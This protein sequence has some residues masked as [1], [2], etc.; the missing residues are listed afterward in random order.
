LIATT[1]E[2][3]IPLTGKVGEAQKH[4]DALEYDQALPLLEEALAMSPKD[5]VTRCRLASLQLEMGKRD[6]GVENYLIAAEHYGVRG[7][8]AKTLQIYKILVLVDPNDY[9]LHE[10]MAFIAARLGDTQEAAN[11]FKWLID[12]FLDKG[13][14]QKALESVNRLLEV[15]P[16]SVEG[17]LL[18][19]D[20]LAQLGDASRCAETLALEIQNKVKANNLNDAL[21]LA[22]RGAEL[23]P[24]NALLNILRQEVAAE[25]QG[26]GTDVERLSQQLRALSE[27]SASPAEDDGFRSWIAELEDD[28]QRFEKAEKR[29]HET[30]EIPIQ[31]RRVMLC[32]DQLKECDS[33]KNAD[34]VRSLARDVPG[35]ERSLGSWRSERLREKGHR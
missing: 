7:Q 1:R 6:Q 5:E 9:N 32:R 28:I 29:Y 31:D 30:G 16:E 25:L 18:K 14:H 11:R 20:L 15:M 13:Q 19:A 21:R 2:I 3:M 23:L 26:R 24:H 22:D 17:I 10:Q 27:E 12:Q 34:D 35:H 8:L 4:I 33:A